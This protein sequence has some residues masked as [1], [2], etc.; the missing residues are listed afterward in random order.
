M[1]CIGMRQVPLIFIEESAGL[2]DHIAS[3]DDVEPFGR[4]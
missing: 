2:L 3:K 4:P 1:R